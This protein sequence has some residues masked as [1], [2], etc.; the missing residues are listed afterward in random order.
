MEGC[1]LTV[2]PKEFVLRFLY[3]FIREHATVF[4]QGSAGLD[5]A[6]HPACRLYQQCVS[7]TEDHL[8]FLLNHRR[9][10][11]PSGRRWTLEGCS[12]SAIL[13]MWQLSS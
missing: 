6:K 1:I 13:M 2:I 7:C 12:T 10:Q 9:Y 8:G 11:S 5:V 4:Y 3:L